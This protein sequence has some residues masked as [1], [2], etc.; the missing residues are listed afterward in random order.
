M[1]EIFEKIYE[2]NFW[3][4]EESVSGTGST[5]EETAELRLFLPSLLEDIDA[6]SILDIPCG[7]LNWIKEIIPIEESGYIGADIVPKLIEK[8]KAAYPGGDFR[9]LDIARSDLP[10]VDVVLVRDLLGHFSNLDVKLALKNLRRSGSKY[11]LATTFP[12][13]QTRGDIKTGQWRPINLASYFGL[14]EPIRLYPES[15]VDFGDHVSVK[16][17]G[18]WNLREEY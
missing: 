9:V 11:L 13:E 15:N 7:D 12:N 6:N 16:C 3:R 4:S 10:Q 17:L 2:D 14:P 8:N 5:L 18:S 1:K